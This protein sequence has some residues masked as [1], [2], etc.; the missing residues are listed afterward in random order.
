[1]LELDLEEHTVRSLAGRRI[2]TKEKEEDRRTHLH[3]SIISLNI[4]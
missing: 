2:R 3:L 1:M 4:R